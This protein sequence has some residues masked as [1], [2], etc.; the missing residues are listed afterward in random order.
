MG[1]FIFG[2]FANSARASWLITRGFLS[3][4]INNESSVNVS[5]FVVI[6]KLLPVSL[7]KNCASTL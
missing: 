6:T 7:V 2:L 4:N 3:V 1:R 5:K